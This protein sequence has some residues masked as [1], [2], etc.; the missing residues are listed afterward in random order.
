MITL[1]A[2]TGVLQMDPEVTWIQCGCLWWT[3]IF[4]R[5]NTLAMPNM[6]LDGTT[7]IHLCRFRTSLPS[8][9]AQGAP[10]GGRSCHENLDEVWPFHPSCYLCAN[11]G[12][13]LSQGKKVDL[14][15]LHI[16]EVEVQ[17]SQ[18]QRD[19]SGLLSSLTC[20]GSSAQQSASSSV[21][22]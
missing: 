20:K 11:S 21:M 19:I 14:G 9:F 12:E 2:M 5:G 16:L 10:C 8:S 1:G 18:F 22:L 3:I 7:P 13:M 15:S 6:S 4:C 17:N